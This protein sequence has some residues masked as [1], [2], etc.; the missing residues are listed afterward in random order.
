MAKRHIQPPELFG[1]AQFGYTQVIASP[2]GTLVFVAG[3]TAWNEKLEL[4]GGTDLGAQTEQA[5]ANLRA[6]LRAAGATPADVTTLRIYIVDYDVEKMRAVEGP[7]RRFFAGGPPSAQ[8]LLGVQALALPGMLI[9]I[10]AMAV[11]DG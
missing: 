10:E 6:A 11:V 5:L 8:T 7:L 4:V 3:Q 1:S 9:E 2:P